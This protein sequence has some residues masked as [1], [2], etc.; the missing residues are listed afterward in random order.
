[1]TE[2]HRF[3][4]TAC[5]VHHC[6]TGEEDA[7]LPTGCP[8]RE[9][10][11]ALE[12]ARHAYRNS[13]E[14]RLS[15]AA[16]RTESRGYLEWPRVREIVEFARMIGSRR[17]G[18]AFCSGLRREAAAAADIFTHHGFEVYPVACKVG[19][20]P[21]EELG[22]QDR[23]KVRPGGHESAC[24]PVGQAAVLAECG[25]DLNIVIGLCVGHD[26]LFFQHSKAPVTVLVAKDRVTGHNPVAALYGAQGYFRKRVLGE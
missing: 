25:T 9:H 15:Q 11:A 24:N 19:R 1:M 8:M 14:R 6:S 3:H 23:D 12:R 26:T 7:T 22:L 18:I 21:K 20:L 5:K 10:P 13:E 16:A 17:L 2:K 4:C